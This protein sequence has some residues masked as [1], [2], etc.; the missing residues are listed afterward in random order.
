[1]KH[2][3][4]ELDENFWLFEKTL[5]S[6]IPEVPEKLMKTLQ[7]YCT[8]LGGV[9]RD[10]LDKPYVKEH[11]E[12]FSICRQRDNMISQLMD[13]LSYIDKQNQEMIG[14]LRNSYKT[15]YDSESFIEAY[16][17]DHRDNPRAVQQ[18][19]IS[20]QKNAEK[21]KK[22]YEKWIAIFKKVTEGRDCIIKYFA[23]WENKTK[24][25]IAFYIPS[26][27]GEFHLNVPHNIATDFGHWDEKNDMKLSISYSEPGKSCIGFRC[28]SYDTVCRAYTFEELNSEFI[29]AIQT[30]SETHIFKTQNDYIEMAKDGFTKLLNQ[31]LQNP[32]QIKSDLEAEDIEKIYGEMSQNDLQ[33]FDTPTF[34]NH[35][36]FM[37][38]RLNEET[39]GTYQR[40]NNNE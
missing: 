37:I 21:C 29:K 26:Y 15:P 6:V 35:M 12:A 8:S 5:K 36:N 23:E 16:Y 27:V 13:Y 34:I 28:F 25:Y 7:L 39:Y 18:K 19:W 4:E 11:Q 32:S 22:S 2:N 30:N 3:Q 31:H 20:D 17:W 10:K 33:L 38:R 24:G 1:M 9:F 40:N 14:C